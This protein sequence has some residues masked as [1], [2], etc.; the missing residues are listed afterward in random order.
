MINRI[1]IISELYYPEETSTGYFLTRIAEGL[2]AQFSVGVLCSQPTY[3]SRGRRALSDE[4]HNGVKIHRCWS[5]T[6]NKDVLTL[7]LVNIA[8]IALSIFLNGLR[9]F[10][11]GDCVIVVTNPPLLP[12]AVLLASRLCGSRCCLLIHDVYP[13]VLVASGIAKQNSLNVRGIGWLTQQ[14]YK[15]MACIIV[16]GR[17]M[18]RLV[19]KKLGTVNQR[20]KIITNWADVDFIRPYDRLDHPLLSE[21]GLSDKFIIQYS[22]NIGRTHGVEQIAACAEVLENDP[23]VHFLFIGFGGKKLWLAQ[24][25][26]K[27]GLSNMTIMD[28]RPRTELSIS[29]TACDLSIISFVR[30][31]AGVSVPSRMYNVMAA[32]KPIIAVAD[33]DSELALVVKEEEIGWVVPPGNVDGLRMAILEAKTNPD[34]LVQMGQ[35]ARRAAETKYSFERVKKAYAEMVA[36]IYEEAV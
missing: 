28:Y 16:L 18:D 8:T 11:S 1:W 7:R 29:L 15:R 17:D 10:R 36:S 20:I 33:S 31:M 24:R 12:F 26:R 3:S 25:V 27:R 22:G 30:G 19:R 13:E 32:G 5:T 9:R 35:R 14:L 2:A 23:S 34:L 6:F 4:T 21:L